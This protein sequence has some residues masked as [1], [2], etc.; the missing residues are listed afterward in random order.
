MS[1]IDKLKSLPKAK[2]I[3]FAGIGAVLIVGIIVAVIL[4]SNN[5]YTATTMRLL[6]VEGT[7]NIEDSKLALSLLSIR[8]DSNQAMH[9]IQEVTELHLSVLM[10]RKS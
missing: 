10:I 8:S 7:V 4:I 3:A 2:K 1:V 9:L 5:G 6:R